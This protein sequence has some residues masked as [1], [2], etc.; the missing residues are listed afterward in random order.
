[1]CIRDRTV[2]GRHSHASRTACR[3]G[4]NYITQRDM[5]LTQFGFIGFAILKPQE[6]GIIG[7]EKD[8]EGFIH[9]W[10]VIGHLMGIQ[11]KYDII[12][13]INN[14]RNSIKNVP[15]ICSY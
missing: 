15:V 3:S 7:S 2:R 11:D 8:V 4:L 5:A 9:F 6:L 12:L 1:M 13:T 10:R 14:N